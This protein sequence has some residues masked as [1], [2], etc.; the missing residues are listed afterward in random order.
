MYDGMTANSHVNLL[1][2]GYNIINE[3]NMFISKT[4]IHKRLFI[5]YANILRLGFMYNPSNSWCLFYMYKCKLKEKK[6]E[7]KEN[8]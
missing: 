5:Y 7:K 3:I 2:H 6:E 1:Q 4:Y 8:K